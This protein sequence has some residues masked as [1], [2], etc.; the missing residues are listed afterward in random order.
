MTAKSLCTFLITFILLTGTSASASGQANECTS[1]IKTVEVNGA[2]L[3]YFECGE[4]EPLVFVHG[5]TGDLN[6]ASPHAQFLA[7]QF[8][9]ISYSRR[10]HFPNDPPQAG[11]AY[12]LQ[13]H[14]D[15]LAALI[16]ELDLGPA[17][18]IG[19]SYGGYVALAFAL[20]HP[21][22]VS[23]LVLGEPPVLPLLTRTS[24]GEDLLNSFN[25]RALEP[26]R[27]AYKQGKMKEGLRRFLN[28]VFYQGWFEEL[29][30]EAQDGIVEKA[31]PQHRLELLTE[32]SVVMP[33]ITCDA[34]SKFDHPTLLMT[35]EESPAM[36]FLVTAELEKCLQG[37]SHIMVPEAGH[38]MFSNTSFF[39]ESVQ[40]F[41]ED[42]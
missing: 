34:L 7:P 19:H 12:A 18:V 1:I 21:K 26:A 15:D 23:S 9:T 32:S 25:R 40:T 10:F 35:G 42:H 4:G 27:E 3:H 22:L 14:V 2:T 5:S 17:H 33:P 11:D 24:V 38:T 31:G 37:E 36:F 41:L 28:G 29:P 6:W 39:N 20:E 8:R 13:L 30:L 16:T